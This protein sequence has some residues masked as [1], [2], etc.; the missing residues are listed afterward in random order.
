M[1]LVCATTLYLGLRRH[2][3]L[4]DAQYGR[5]TE[6][7]T[8]QPPSYASGEEEERRIRGDDIES[9]EYKRRWGLEGM[10][11]AEIVELGDDHPAH[12]FIL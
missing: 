12:R 5:I 10:S 8:T 1:G 6:S 7:L 4:R 3:R 11:R 9:E 2:N